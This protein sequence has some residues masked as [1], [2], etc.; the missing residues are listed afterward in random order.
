MEVYLT[1]QAVADELI[2][3]SG[4]S[5]QLVFADGVCFLRDRRPLRFRVAEH[6]DD[7]NR[8]HQGNHEKF[9]PVESLDGEESIQ[10]LDRFCYNLS[11]SRKEDHP[12]SES[13]YWTD[14]LAMLYQEYGKQ[15]NPLYRTTFA[16]GRSRHV[17]THNQIILGN[18]YAAGDDIQEFE[19]AKRLAIDAIRNAEHL[20]QNPER[21]NL[22][23]HGKAHLLLSEVE[24]KLGRT[25]NPEQ[26]SESIRIALKQINRACRGGSSVQDYMSLSHLYTQTAILISMGFDCGRSF[27][28]AER[29]ALSVMEQAERNLTSGDIN[30]RNLLSR[31]RRK[32]AEA[33]RRVGPPETFHSQF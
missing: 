13:S 3:K 14:L 6:I 1:P 28:E 29:E 12:R 33:A 8:T 9:I 16:P 17:A 4:Y 5:D 7:H 30:Y 19:L 32:L 26:I 25:G 15:V 31:D 18:K 22:R 27:E 21:G 10:L 11:K 24:Q 2:D 20:L 23:L